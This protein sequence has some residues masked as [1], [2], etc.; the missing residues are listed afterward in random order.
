MNLLKVIFK[1]Y[2]DSSSLKL[3][4]RLGDDLEGIK[5]LLEIDEKPYH[6]W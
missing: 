6:I 2:R 5:T 3:W 1:T 4:I